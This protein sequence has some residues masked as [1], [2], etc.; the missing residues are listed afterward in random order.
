MRR[1]ALAL[2]LALAG[3]CALD[4]PSGPSPTEVSRRF[5]RDFV[6]IL[7]E[8]S[9]RRD[10]IDWTALRAAVMAT[11]EGALTIEA[12]EDAL[13]TGLEMLEDNHSWIRRPDGQ[14]VPYD[15]AFTCTAPDVVSPTDIPDDVGYL[16]I[17]AFSGTVAE[18]GAY[19]SAIQTAMQE[20]DG[21]ALV[22]WIIDLRGNGGGNM[23]P[24]LAALWPFLQGTVGHFVDAYDSW[25]EWYVDGPYSYLDGYPL[26]EAT[27]PYEPQATDG[28][29]AVLTDQRVASSGEAT[30]VAFRGRP[31]TRSFGTPTCGVP[32]G[33]VTGPLGYGYTLGIATVWMA[34]RDSTRYGTP[35]APDEMITDPA[36]VVT[37]AIEWIRTGM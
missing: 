11:G 8:Y 33:I 32:T 18:E 20:Q 10:S 24:M 17:G 12:T 27:Y 14:F 29:V 22:G 26:G 5:L 37:R 1:L 36:A 31:S 9:V 21:D 30:A 2:T 16:R 23:W 3:G 4:G 6:D 34:D 15:R 28:R 25:A 7:E 35:L 13:A 19:T